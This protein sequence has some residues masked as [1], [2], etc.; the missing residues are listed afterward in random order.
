MNTDEESS[1]QNWQ[2]ECSNIKKIIHHDQMGFSP[3]FKV[4]LTFEDQLI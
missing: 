4:G 3:E 1:T 2:T